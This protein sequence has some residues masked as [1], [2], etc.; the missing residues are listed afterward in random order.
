MFLCGPR[1]FLLQMD[2]NTQT[3]QLTE[4]EIEALGLKTYFLNTNDSGRNFICDAEQLKNSPIGQSALMEKPLGS[5]ENP[6]QIIQDGNTLST[7]QN[8]SKND[9]ELIANALLTKPSI[10][11]NSVCV[12]ENGATNFI[13]RVVYPEEL[14]LKVFIILIV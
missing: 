8:V 13:Y 2:G 11:E 4:D 12:Q 10:P 14:N 3:L 7:T 6:I 9:L 1:V 5:S